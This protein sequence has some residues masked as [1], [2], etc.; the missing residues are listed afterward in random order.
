VSTKKCIQNADSKIS[1]KGILVWAKHKWEVSTKMT[2]LRGCELDGNGPR[3]CP[4]N[5]FWG[6][7]DG[8]YGSVWRVW[9]LWIVQEG[10]FPVLLVRFVTFRAMKIQ[11][12]ACVL[13]RRISTGHNSDLLTELS[14]TFNK[15]KVT[16]RIL[17]QDLDGNSCHFFKGW[18][19]ALIV[20]NL[21][22]QMVSIKQ[23]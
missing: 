16:F 20:Q 14:L 21:V 5:N 13:W 4:T 7:I 6:G 3:Y 9:Y 15:E 22:L 2:K 18:R 1:R 19:R 10:E 12:M 23:T 8:R 17:T 11:V